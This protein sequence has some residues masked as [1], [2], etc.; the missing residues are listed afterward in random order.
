MIYKPHYLENK[1]EPPTT[2]GCPPNL[3][4]LEDLSSPSIQL[5]VSSPLL[6]RTVNNTR[7]ENANS[8]VVLTLI[9]NMDQCASTSKTI[10]Q[11][12]F[13]QAVIS[14]P[15]IDDDIPLS[16]DSQSIPK[17]AENFEWSPF[18]THLK[19]SDS[20]I[21]SRKPQKNKPKIPPC[22]SGREFCNHLVNIQ[23]KKAE[24]I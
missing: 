17:Y 18:K 22:I 24:E 23:E 2:Q 11:E 1:V 5:E 8:P 10:A 19:I 20:T 4:E 6:Q 3:E 15:P 16:F 12:L 21:I 9:E 13:P 14:D 7:A